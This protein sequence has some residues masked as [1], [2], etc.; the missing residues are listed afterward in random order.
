MSKKLKKLRLYIKQ[1]FSYPL[2]SQ[3]VAIIYLTDGLGIKLYIFDLYL[4]LG[5]LVKIT[6]YI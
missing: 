3:S 5:F 6:S 2:M 1:H 4:L